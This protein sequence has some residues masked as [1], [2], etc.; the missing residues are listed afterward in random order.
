[1]NEIKNTNREKM[2]M[3]YRL[4]LILILSHELFLMIHNSSDISIIKNILNI[5]SG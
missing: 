1:M 3:I 2:D 4:K 5:A